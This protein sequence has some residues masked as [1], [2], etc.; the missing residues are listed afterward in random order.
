MNCMHSEEIYLSLHLQ[1]VSS[2]Q[3][4]F[5]EYLYGLGCSLSHRAEDVTI[6]DKHFIKV[7]F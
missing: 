6:R 1:E 3:A 5:M 4:Q 7:C 2:A